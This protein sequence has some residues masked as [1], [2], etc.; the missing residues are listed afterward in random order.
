MNQ[1]QQSLQAWIAVFTGMGEKGAPDISHLADIANN[2]VRFVDPFNDIR[3]HDALHR[4]LQHTARQVKKVQFSVL[5]Q[6]TSDS[7]VYLKWIMQG[8]IP[9][10][11]DWQ[12]AGLSEIHFDEAGLIKL[13]QDYWDAAEQFY[14]HLP[15]IGWQLRRIRRMTTA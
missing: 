11:G 2:N 3:G 8:Q 5:D 4:L 7:A 6:A 9:V 1:R 12:V 13:H 10:I 14:A 15:I